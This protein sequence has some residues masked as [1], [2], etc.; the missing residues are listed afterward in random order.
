MIPRKNGTFHSVHAANPDLLEFRGMTFL[1][2]RGQGTELHDQ[3]G[4]ACVKSEKFNGFDWDFHEGNPVI[5]VS[6]KR[7]DHDSRHILDPGTVVFDDKVYL[8]YS[9]HSYDKPAAICLAVSDDGFNF[10]KYAGNP[11]VTGAIAPEVV[12]FNG[13]IHLFYQKKNNEGYFEFY[14]ATSNDGLSFVNERKVFGP[15]INSE[16][17]DSFSVSTCR[18]WKE[19]EWFYMI[20]GGSDVFDD[21]PSAF[22]LAKSNDL[23]TWERYSGNPVFNRGEA[24]SWDEGG[25]W[26][27]TVY[28]HGDTRYMWYEGCGTD[29]GLEDEESRK[30]SNICRTE[31]YGGYGRF[32]FSQIGMAVSKDRMDF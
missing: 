21:Y 28:K 26:F 16:E 29:M 15:G 19:D 30:L 24:G 18:I 9:G 27:G 2:F 22:G 4:I 7:D 1:Y 8:Y 11:I 5:K 6:D 23:I 10:E 32:N 31:D 14:C 17:F 3:I 25:V 20:Y 12:I 13:L